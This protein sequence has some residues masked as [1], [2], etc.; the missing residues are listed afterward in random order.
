ME[1]QDSAQVAFAENHEVIMPTYVLRKKQLSGPLMGDG[2]N[3]YS[4]MLIDSGFEGS[5]LQEVTGQYS[6]TS[7]S[8]YP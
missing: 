8:R 3:P 4:D 1:Y 7:P 5:V 2:P 6:T